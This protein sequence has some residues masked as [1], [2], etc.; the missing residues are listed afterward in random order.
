MLSNRGLT[1]LYV[2]PF[3]VPII[4]G[5]ESVVYE[6]SL[7]LLKLGHKPVVLTS[8]VTGRPDR[9][10]IGG[11]EVVRTS[12]LDVPENGTL[13]PECFSSTVVSDFLR[14]IIDETKVDIIHL[15]NYQ[16]KQYAM[17]LHSF[18]AAIRGSRTPV[19]ITIH[20]TTDDPFCHYLLSYL[21]FSKIIALTSKSAFDLING[22]VP[23]GRIGVHPN[24]LDTEKFSE[25]NGAM[26]RR[27]LGI[28]M[29]PVILFPSRLVGREAKQFR[30]EDGKGLEVLL[31]AL[32]LIKREI[33]D[34][35]LLLMGNDS[36]YSDRVRQV[37]ERLMKTAATLGAPDSVFFIDGDIPQEQLPSVFAAS[38]IV[39]SLGPTECFGM[40]FLEGMA[41]GKPVVGV[42][43]VDNGVAEVIH[44]GRSGFLVPPNDPWNTAKTIIRVLSEKRL[45]EKVGHE[46]K[47]W[48]R[49][50][51]GIDVVLP[52][53]IKLYNQCLQ[54]TGYTPM[55]QVHHHEPLPK[56]AIGSTLDI[57]KMPRPQAAGLI[58]YL[59][60]E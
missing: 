8:R 58:N 60:Q 2:T 55:E 23:T 4:G 26:V 56:V 31:R 22:G 5:V 25:A 51:Y 39:V 57:D 9:E 52:R 45:A 37:R 29:E 46:A 30:F 14:R 48:V 32:P 19:I 6:S 1:V 53:L 24:M 11:I 59:S 28:D 44:D 47:R 36:V 18:F 13:D 12:L 40:I 10:N 3:F 16:M 27:M 15:H 42:N 7:G 35:K 21:P 49:R 50:T 54:E 38:D 34:A 43:S 20:N 41:A 33:P 17:F